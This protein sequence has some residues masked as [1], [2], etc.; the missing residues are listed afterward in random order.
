MASMPVSRHF[1]TYSMSRVK[2]AALWA[3]AMHAAKSSIENKCT[4]HSRCR[5]RRSLD[6][7]WGPRGGHACSGQ[8]IQDFEGLINLVMMDLRPSRT[9]SCEPHAAHLL[10]SERQQRGDHHSKATAAHERRQLQLRA[11]MGY[12]FMH[13]CG[14]EALHAVR[15]VLRS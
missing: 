15:V 8:A 4:L 1:S 5:C 13:G 3:G 12:A 14:P 7:G 2:H 6:R 9:P 10:R 11:A